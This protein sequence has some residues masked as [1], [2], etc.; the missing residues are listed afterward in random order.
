MTSCHVR[1]AMGLVATLL[2][3]GARSDVKNLDGVPTWCLHF[4]GCPICAYEGG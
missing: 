4:S 2:R 1:V 3:I